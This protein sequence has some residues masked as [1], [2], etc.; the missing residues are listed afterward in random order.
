MN[1]DKLSVFHLVQLIWADETKRS[2]GY[3]TS[4]DMANRTGIAHS[5]W[6]KLLAGSSTLKPAPKTYMLLACYL[7]KKKP[8]LETEDGF[9]IPTDW[10]T[11]QALDE[12]YRKSGTMSATEAV[13][14]LKK[15]RARESELIE[16]IVD[17]ANNPRQ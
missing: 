14:E 15:L 12:A 8:S 1:L 11:L 9:L 3:V 2:S 16:I 5:T 10:A 7:S 4:R 13:A 6:H 17:K